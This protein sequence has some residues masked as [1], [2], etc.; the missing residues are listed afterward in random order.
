[1]LKREGA[2]ML[3][4]VGFRLGN[5]SR[6]VTAVV[7][8]S[9]RL[10]LAHGAY[11][12]VGRASRPDRPV[13]ENPVHRQVVH[14]RGLY[15]RYLAK[16]YSDELIPGACVQ[17]DLE[18]PAP[19]PVPGKSYD[20]EHR[21]PVLF[22]AFGEV[23]PAQSHDSLEEAINGFYTSIGAPFLPRR[24][25][26]LVSSQPTTR[27][28]RRVAALRRVLADGSAVSS[29]PR[30]AVGYTVTADD[31]RLHVGRAGESLRH[32]DVVEL[33]AALSAWLHLNTMK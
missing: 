29:P 32:R 14:L 28:P 19:E 8:D 31:V 18:E 25:N 20:I 9:G 22:R 23:A 33:H 2:A 17:L 12:A 13:R 10:H 24:L 1:M 4:V 7:T 5:G 6:H 30:M 11:G 3:T 21:W 27:L 26:R 15:S 16:G